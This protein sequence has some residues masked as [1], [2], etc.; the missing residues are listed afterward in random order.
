MQDKDF[1]CVLRCFGLEPE[2]ID[3]L[4]AVDYDKLS[5]LGL[6]KLNPF[7][8]ETKYFNGY[9]KHVSIDP[10][11]NVDGRSPN[12]FYMEATKPYFKLMTFHKLWKVG[13]SIYDDF[14]LKMLL[15]GYVYFHDST[16]GYVPYCV[17][18]SCLDIIQH[19]R[20][21][22]EPISVPPKR[23]DSYVAMCTEFLMDMSQEFAGAVAFTD[24]LVGLAWFTSREEVTNKYIENRLQSFVHVAN[25]KFRVGG[26]SPF[27]NISVNSEAVLREVFDNYIFP[28]ERRIADF[29]DEVMRVQRIFLNFMYLGRPEV[30][31]LPYKFPIVT[32]NFKKENL[33]D[34]EELDTE[35]FDYVARLNHKGFININTS[36]RFAMCCR[37][38]IDQFKFNSFGGGGLKLGSFR[39]INVNLPRIAME[40]ATLKVFDKSLQYVLE[41]AHKL[42]NIE[43]LILKEKIEQR[44]LKFF[45]IG[46]YNLDNMF[47]GTLSFH[48]LPD[49]IDILIDK[50][51]SNDQAQLLTSLIIRNF[52]DEASKETNYHINV[53]QAPSESATDTMARLNGDTKP[54]YSNQFVPLDL[55][56][57][58][59]MRIHI[60]GQFSD[61]MT[62]GSMCFVNLDAPMDEQQSLKLHKYVY[63]NSMINQWAIN[64]GWSICGDGHLNIGEVEECQ[65]CGNNHLK[66]YERV[67]GYLVR[68]DKVNP[69]REIEML[70][71]VRHQNIY[72]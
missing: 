1:F 9:I 65:K 43:R 10:N 26:D 34:V 8:F 36:P 45:N 23:S 42:L 2:F 19:G 18:A 28:D 47:F 54:Y 6:N 55:P 68:R 71:R 69:S 12:N 30:E 3:E 61:M 15:E 51:M 46:W 20:P 24:F 63:R 52:L 50:D 31:G 70:N 66:Y 57:D 40:S 64:F 22:G 35:W 49:S 37:L 7:E 17:G 67:V 39:V 25:N 21:Y 58:L 41:Y 59:G 72:I 56:I 4:R 38:N 13:K 27:S 16:K 33:D 29:I 60:E 14:S 44:F 32:A 53:E 5:I 48:G 62:G 11:A